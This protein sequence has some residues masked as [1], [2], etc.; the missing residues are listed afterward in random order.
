[1]DKLI[2]FYWPLEILLCLLPDSTTL[3]LTICVGVW[4]WG[5]YCQELLFSSLIED[6]LTVCLLF[7]SD[8]YNVL[9]CFCSWLLSYWC[10]LC[11]LWITCNWTCWLS[12]A[13]ELFNLVNNV[14]QYRAKYI[15]HYFAYDMFETI[16]K[17]SYNVILHNIPHVLIHLY[18]FNLI[19]QLNTRHLVSVLLWTS[20][21]N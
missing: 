12:R 17:C 16:E 3:T 13:V 19:N 5:T 11:V 14:T 21:M 6:W 18:L 8:M 2:R 7:N 9:I 15:N 20:P 1:M 10:I 4:T